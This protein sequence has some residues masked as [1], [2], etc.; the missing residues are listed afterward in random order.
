MNLP[1]RENR[2]DFV[3]GLEAGGD[4]NRRFQAREGQR[5]SMPMER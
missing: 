4:G 2:T 3:D 1:K 5:Q